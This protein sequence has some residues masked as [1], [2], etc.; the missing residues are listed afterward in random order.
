MY[1]S[2]LASLC[3]EDVLDK[4]RKQTVIVEKYAFSDERNVVTGTV[5][6][7]NLAFEKKVQVCYTFNDWNSRSD[8]NLIWEGSVGVWRETDKFGIVIPLPDGWSGR[9]EFFIRYEVN[10]QTYLDSNDGKNYE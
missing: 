2:R 5:R 4:V 6:V 1:R 9:V 8:L 3:E 10:G 7:A